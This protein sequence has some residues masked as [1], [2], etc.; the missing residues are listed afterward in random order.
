M[1]LTIFTTGGTIDKVYFD[2]KS[3]YEVGEPLI[4]EILQ[5]A[6]VTF[7]FDVITLF[8]K[9][10]LDLTDADRFV[11]VE[12]VRE[13]EDQRIVITHG[14]DTMVETARAIEE[15]ETGKVV[16]LV[17]ALNPA[18]FR[19]SDAIFNIGFAM[20]AVQTLDAGVYIAMN[21]HLFAP[22]R[23]RKNRAANQFEEV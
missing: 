17:G 2:A 12:S 8:Q 3:D 13:C 7:D 21:G 6:K 4:G 18:R 23:V 11:I 19:S 10:S 5:D 15:A 16:V 20:A 22:D 1:H 9:D 14:T